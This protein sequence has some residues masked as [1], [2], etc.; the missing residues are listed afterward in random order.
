MHWFVVISQKEARVFRKDPARRQLQLL[1]S[2]KNPLGGVK[3]SALVKKEAGRGLKSMGRTGAV[4]YSQR[5]RHD[6]REDASQ[7]FARKIFKYLRAR[8]LKNKF[9]TLT[10]VV[11]PKL[12]GKIR[13]EMDDSIQNS[14]TSWIRKDFQKTPKRDIKNALLPKRVPSSNQ[15]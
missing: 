2:L 1:D 5:K 14:V 15:V 13:G 12:L 8:K 6:P 3:R 10:V 9:E 11:E 4:G 7:Q